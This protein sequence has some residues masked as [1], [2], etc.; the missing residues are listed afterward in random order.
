M[1]KKQ[2]NKH[3]ISNFIANK[4][5]S[6]LVTVLIAVAFIVILASIVISTSIVNYRMKGIDRKNKTDFYSAEKALNDIYTGLGQDVTK[7]AANEYSNAMSKLNK[8][9][10]T[11][12]LTIDT[13]DKADREYRRNFYVA[14]CGPDSIAANEHQNPFLM[15]DQDASAPSFHSGKGIVE[16]LASYIVTPS[17]WEVHP[18]TTSTPVKKVVVEPGSAMGVTTDEK[19]IVEWDDVPTTS[20]IIEPENNEGIHLDASDSSIESAP[21]SLPWSSTDKFTPKNNCIRLTG[22]KVTAVD[23]AGYQSIVS[24]DIVIATPS[25]DFFGNNSDINGFALV[26]N[27]GILFN[28]AGT[29]VSGSIYGGIGDVSSPV[30]I[31]LDQN[32]GSPVKL[33][34]DYIVSGGDITVGNGSTLII[35]DDKYKANIWCESLKTAKTTGGG[36]DSATKLY[37]GGDSSVSVSTTRPNTFALNDL[38]LDSDSSTVYVHGSYYGYNT[39]TFTGVAGAEYEATNTANSRNS[40]IIVNGNNSSLNMED[41][42]TF[43]LM[44]KAYLDFTENPIANTD[45]D[46]KEIATGEGVAL[47]SNQQLYLLPAEFLLDA[48]NPCAGTFSSAMLNI[49]HVMDWFAYDFVKNASGSIGTKSV[50]FTK[51]SPSGGPDY[52]YSYVFLDFNDSLWTYNKATN[53]VSYYGEAS[54]TFSAG[55]N[56]TISS[57]DAYRLLIL[58]ATAGDGISSKTLEP[59]ALTLRNKA[60][61]TMT[62]HSFYNLQQAVVANGSNTNIYAQNTVVQYKPDAANYGKSNQTV[63]ENNNSYGRYN[64]YPQSLF[65]RFKHLCCYLN[66]NG[67]YAL[68]DAVP[69][70]GTPTDWTGI[71]EDSSAGTLANGLPVKHIIDMSSGLPTSLA[72]SDTYTDSNGTAVFTAGNYARTIIGQGDVTLPLGT[73]TEF[74]GVAIIDGNVTVKASAQI[75]GLIIAT[76]TITVMDGVVIEQDASMIQKRI[77]KEV[78]LIKSGES[79]DDC[80]LINWLSNPTTGGKMYDVSAAE[81]YQKSENRVEFDYNKFMY[82]ENWDKGEE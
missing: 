74:T 73:D 44:G 4:K 2:K 23:K 68:G 31:R 42:D 36:A 71:K 12:T 37:V 43:I 15:D 22:L 20:S 59:T 75:H 54:S 6:T 48:S 26:A 52:V 46:E 76:G 45:I 55:T 62:N 78:D 72:D 66:T 30:G 21:M 58:N 11:N 3:I 49:P 57:Q 33:N 65:N 1:N 24:T 53:T 38:Q 5:G 69:D 18:D 34:G 41:L 79:Y 32:L 10:T 82:Y 7:I 61:K 47:K 56:G 60:E 64:L 16:T 25:M 67:D 40:A 14:L 70:I 35:G 8:K 80:F 19:F 51:H 39:G 13:P 77:S 50:K 28:G 9:D 29:E 17:G 63:V 27:K 81:D